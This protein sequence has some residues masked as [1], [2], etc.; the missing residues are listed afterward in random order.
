MNQMVTDYSIL[1]AIWFLRG[2][3]S[4]SDMR[5]EIWNYLEK[6]KEVYQAFC[7]GDIK[8]HLLKMWKDGYWGTNIELLAFSDLIRININIY[9]SLNQD[10]S[11]FKINHSHNT[12]E[13]NIFL[14]NWRY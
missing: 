7:E 5:S 3:S 1:L 12:G 6:K 4:A 2:K 13:R 11:E 8:K 10:H 9:T 14:R